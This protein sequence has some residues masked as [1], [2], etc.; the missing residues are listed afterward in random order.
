MRVWVDLTNTAHVLVL[1]PLVELLEREGHEVTLT[2]RP[3]SHTL[4]L[5]D[6]WGHPHTALGSYGGATRLGKAR[7]AASRI[8]QLLRFGRKRRFDCAL[9]HGST[10]LP[11]ACLPLR[12][13]NTTMFDYEWA[14]LQH[15][16]NCRLASRVLVPEAIPAKRLARYGAK[17][18]KLVHYPGLKEEYYLSDFEPDTAVLDSLGLD[19]ERVLCVVR[20]APSYAL[21]LRGS[22]NSLLPRL[23]SR[24][25]KA[26]EAQT[27][28]LARNDR[29]RQ[30][31]A[32]LGLGRIVVP[33][34]AVDG[35]SLVALADVLVSGG[36]TMNREAAVLGTPV[37]SI[38]EGRLGA[39]DE[40]LVSEGRLRPL[41]DPDEVELVKKA[42]GSYERRTRRDPRDLLR[43]A[44][45]WLR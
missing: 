9:A 1:R 5:L 13:P 45:P 35:R 40:G 32:A 25:G 28:V 22:E 3:L 15:H 43:L 7:A 33:E 29:Q 26:E 12:V 19:G 11:A 37:W 39:V 16:V 24:L 44:L 36:G 8:P 34:R 42:S 23:L 18:P 20:T 4:E 31:V 6:E 10:D 17:P 38:F 27:V 30:E 41:K 14:S 21:Y 2:A